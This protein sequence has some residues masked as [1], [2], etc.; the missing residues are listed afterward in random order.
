MS[1]GSFQSICASAQSG[2]RA[3]KSPRAAEGQPSRYATIRLRLDNVS[4]ETG[5]SSGRFRVRSSFHAPA[6]PEPEALSRGR[7][8]PCQSSFSRSSEKQAKQTH[9]SD[10]KTAAHSK[11]TLKHSRSSDRPP[12]F[13]RLTGS[14]TRSFDPCAAVRSAFRAGGAV[15]SNAAASSTV[16]AEISAASPGSP[17]GPSGLRIGRGTGVP[18]SQ[19]RS[20]AGRPRPPP[21]GMDARVRGRGPRTRQPVAI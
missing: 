19:G 4:S 18:G 8:E 9:L 5:K 7:P 15:S 12:T 3:Q 2:V 11:K 1:I 17:A 16:H 13:R 20:A 14:A 10:E 6:S 21:P